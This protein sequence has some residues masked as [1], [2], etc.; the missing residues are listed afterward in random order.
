MNDLKIIEIFRLYYEYDIPC[1]G[2][3]KFISKEYDIHINK[4][5][6]FIKNYFD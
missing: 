4:I 2:I 5:I 6:L 1:V 3:T